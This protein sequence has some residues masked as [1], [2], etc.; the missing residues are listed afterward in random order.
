MNDLGFTI[1]KRANCHVIVYRGGGCHPAS[2]WEV[3]L[4]GALAASQQKVMEL[5]ESERKVREFV[6]LNHGHEGV[7]GDDGEMQCGACMPNWDYKRP[8]L[9]NV[10]RV[11]VG[12]LIT[13]NAALHA[14]VEDLTKANEAL[15]RQ[16]D[17]VIPSVG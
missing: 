4:W 6:W 10:V 15:R 16:L 1:E 12:V 2:T 11:A 3:A 8:P 9:F 5:E 13:D 14:Q 17:S 7:Y